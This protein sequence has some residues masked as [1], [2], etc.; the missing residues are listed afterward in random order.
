VAASRAHRAGPDAVALT[1]ALVALAGAAILPLAELRA[2][3]LVPGVLQSLGVAGAL[4]LL[5]WVALALG[6]AAALVPALAARPRLA[7][8]SAWGLVGATAWALGAACSRLLEGQPTVARVSIGAGAWVLLAGAAIIGF[9]ARGNSGTRSSSLAAR[10]AAPA[11]GIAAVVLA[12]ALGGLDQLSL[13]REYVVRADSFWQLALGHVTLAAAALAAGLA[14]GVPLGLAATRNRRI[15][16]VAL[17][18]TGI[19]QTVPSLALLGLLVVPLAALGAAY[20]V[21]RELGIRGI[22]AAPGLIALTLYALLPIVRNTYVGL[23]EVDPGAIDAGRGMGMSPAQLL[24]RVELPLA[25]PL[26]I[27]G[28]R[29]AAVLLVGI[30]TLTVFAGARNLGILIFEGL[31]Q[32]APDLILL[33]AIPTIA[34]ALIADLGL[35]ALGRALTPEG[36][37]AP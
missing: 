25:L 34:L 22:G 27:E 32:F 26:I 37:R 36:V 3:R 17:G 15:R 21:L 12:F 1:G 30:T 23:S 35:S 29:T 16:A 33:G 11:A 19:I 18:V 28:V 6:F 24:L 5:V 13:A 14:I 10:L 2:N 7:R 31:G 8:A 4:A 20:P 9:A